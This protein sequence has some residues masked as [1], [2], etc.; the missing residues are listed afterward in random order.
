MRDDFPKPTR[1]AVALRAGYR[2]S[3][4]GCDQL[5]VGPSEES[6]FAVC[7]IGVAAHVSA[8][9]SG[10]RRYDPGMSSD[11]RMHINNAIW[12]CANHAT[13]VDRDDVTYTVERLKEM[14]RRHEVRIASILGS[15]SAQPHADSSDLIALG[16]DLVC[17][18]EIVSGS[19][20]DLEI[21]ILH[22]VRGEFPMVVA[23]CERFDELKPLDRHI[24]LAELGDGRVLAAAPSWR[25]TIQ[26]TVIACKFLPRAPRIRAQDLGTDLKL[27]EDHDITPNLE[28][29]SGVDALPQ[30]VQLC[31]SLQKGEWFLERDFGTRLAEYF[32]LFANSIWLDRLAKLEVIRMA[33]IPYRDET[34][35]EEST[36]LQ[37]VERVFAF[38]TIGVPVPGQWFEV[39][40]KLEVSGLG[41]W[42]RTLD[43]YL[44]DKEPPPSLPSAED[45]L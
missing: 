26:G 35:D 2:C 31:L 8:A 32:A 28:T 39:E 10:G 45:L 3:F 17:L 43:I 33:A 9:A 24:L 21:R 1:Q 25:K 37:C 12:L 14:K 44:P 27:D 36:P 23:F 11:E 41:P 22:Y 15:P 29:V 20:N 40:L 42:E 18:G 16:P 30:K 34:L 38:K 7:T 5:T 13:L 6:E 4:D 19:G